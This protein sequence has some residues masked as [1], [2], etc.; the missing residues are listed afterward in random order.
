MTEHVH[1]TD[2]ASKRPNFLIIVA[3]DLGYSDLGCFGSE[4]ST[5]NL[6]AIASGGLRLSSFYTASACSPTRSM[7]FSGTDN[8]LAGLGQMAETISHVDPSL[9]Q[10]KPGYEGMLNQRVAALSEIL[11]EGGYETLM[12]GKWHLGMTKE[13]IPAARGFDKVFT[14]LSG[15]GN[16]YAYEPLLDDNT[17]VIKISPPLYMENNDRIPFQELK[18]FYSSRS[19]ADKLLQYL[20][21]SDG[22][23]PK[24]SYLAMTAPHWPLQAPD[25]NIAKY[26]GFY[27]E[28]PEVLR[29]KRL[30]KMNELGLVDPTKKPA[31]LVTT[32]GTKRWSELSEQERKESAKKMEVYA[33]MI[34]VMDREI[35]RVLDH[36]RE[37]GELDNTFVFFCSDNGAEGALLEAIPMLA[38]EF[39]KL[40]PLH[41]DNSLEN[42]GRK[43]SFTWIGPQWAQATT[44]PH[45]MYKAWNTEG[46]VKCPA[47]L[48]YPAVGGDR[49]SIEP[50]FATIMDILPTILDLAGLKHPAPSFQG[51]QVLAP[52]GRSWVPHL[53][54]KVGDFH[55]ESDIVGWELFGQAAIR[56]GSWKALWLPAPAGPEKW[57]LFD[58]SK[59]P[60]E[61]EDLADKEPRK[62]AEMVEHWRVY[63]AETGTILV[64]PGPNYPG[65]GFGFFT[66]YESVGP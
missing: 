5:P 21:E 8:H 14:L 24:F 46:G 12:A 15:A 52:R 25:E 51:R 3:D 58:L 32:F 63:E 13:S 26:K 16:H 61:Q 31:P 66:G 29:E 40:L 10:G 2:R 18:N 48:R 35:G 44:A 33:A 36:L 38:D 41:F 57:Q 60:G 22:T 4:I 9:F 64:K 53:Q 47:I 19:F 42:I 65:D 6:D 49:G 7:L 34:E 23:R 17:P 28:G 20:K 27:D 43:N 62:L 37:T 54:G 45:R 30:K 59:D 55:E 56:R 50:S 1:I 39:Q 11:Q